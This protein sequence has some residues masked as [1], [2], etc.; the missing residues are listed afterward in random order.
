[1]IFTL[2]ILVFPHVN[3]IRSGGVTAYQMNRCPRH[4]SEAEDG[5]LFS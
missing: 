4:A 3:G 5:A 2:Y 1:M